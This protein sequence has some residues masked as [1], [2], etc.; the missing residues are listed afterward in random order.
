[1]VKNDSKL[2]IKQKVTVTSTNE[3]LGSGVVRSTN[4]NGTAIVILE[5]KS[6]QISFLGGDVVA[7]SQGSDSDN[8][9]A[10]APK[11][12]L[13]AGVVENSSAHNRLKYPLTARAGFG[14]MFTPGVTGG[15]SYNVNHEVAGELTVDS[16]SLDFLKIYKYSRLRIGALGSY[17]GGN[18]FYSTGGLIIEQ[19]TSGTI[20]GKIDDNGIETQA[21][22]FK[23]EFLQL[24]AQIGIGNRWNLGRFVIGAEW[25]GI[26][27]PFV[28]IS[29]KY[30]K[31]EGYSDTQ[32]E[33]SK[34]SNKEVADAKSLR[35]L[36]SYIGF[37][38]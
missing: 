37:S 23:A 21:D 4:P 38:F 5:Q 13:P 30:T 6:C 1:M 22:A 11:S 16:A 7:D 31:T 18:S 32:F 3:D 15:L 14:Y 27:V 2:K 28:N 20:G 10:R 34:K 12:R 8:E 19:F 35:L 33:A 24:Q 25:V 17:F 9:F 29:E 26:S 36:N